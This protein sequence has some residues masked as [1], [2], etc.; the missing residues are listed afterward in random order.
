MKAV[1]MQVLS[2]N[3]KM[4]PPK[5]LFMV[6]EPTE[7]VSDDDSGSYNKLNDMDYEV[8]DSLKDAKAFAREWKG[9]VVVMEVSLKPVHFIKQV[10]VEEVIK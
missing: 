3:T 5:K 7:T 4:I 10:K 9:D 8:F 1:L 2:K 6:G